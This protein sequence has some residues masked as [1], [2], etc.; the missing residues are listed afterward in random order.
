V[1]S[2]ALALQRGI[3]ADSDRLP[4]G[5]YRHVWW[6]VAERTRNFDRVVLDRNAGI[7]AVVDAEAFDE[8]SIRSN[9]R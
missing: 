8:L 1:N 2:Q 6:Y 7:I 4:E 9:L 5:F 3:D